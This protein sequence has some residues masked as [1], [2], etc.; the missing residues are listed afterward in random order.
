LE[1]IEHESGLSG[2]RK[3]RRKRELTLHGSRHVGATGRKNSR[4]I[5]KHRFVMKKVLVCR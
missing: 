1:I 5:V 2:G 4:A 3:V